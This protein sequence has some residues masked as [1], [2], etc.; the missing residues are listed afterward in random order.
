MPRPRYFPLNAAPLRMVAGLSRHGTDFGNGAA[1]A[2]F[3]Q[4]DDRYDA[5]LALK[6]GAP[7]LRHGLSGSDAAAEAARA[8]ALAFIDTTLAREQPDALARALAD[9][10]ARD[11]FEARA[12][13][14]QEDLAVVE[15]GLGHE[16]DDRVVAADIRFPSGF[17]PEQLLGTS[18][19]GI[20]E[21]VPEFVVDPRA[22][23]S[24]VRAMCE[25]G[26]YVRFVWALCADDSLDH[27][28]DVW[29]G[30]A[31]ESAPNAFLRVE[32][33]TTVPL[34]GGTAALFLIRTYLTHV[35]E[36]T[37]GEQHT[38]LCAVAAAPP[39]IAA[40]KRLPSEA[41]LARILA[42]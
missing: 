33:Q 13:V 39:A 6:R 40:Y 31:W 3:F 25:R 42:G 7:L 8:A 34:E 41:A 35:R 27:H 12:L 37:A 32:R 5:T 26:P 19:F 18:F 24:M 4:R 29:S 16:D 22:A 30:N 2:L 15:A 10:T 20:H 38:L 1:D 17:R 11:P 28:P 14:M 21:P 9:T 23:R 36:L